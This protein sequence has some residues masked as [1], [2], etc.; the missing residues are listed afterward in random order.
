MFID[1]RADFRARGRERERNI[2]VREKLLPP[3]Q[4]P[5]G[6]RNSNLG[7]CPDQGSNPQPSGAWF[8]TQPTEPPKQGSPYYFLQLRVNV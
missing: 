7:M 6:N 5:T 2:D 1:L 3:V 4:A 8:N